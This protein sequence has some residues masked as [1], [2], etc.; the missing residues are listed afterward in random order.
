MRNKITHCGGDLAQHIYMISIR[1]IKNFTIINGFLLLMGYLQYY[2]LEYV[3]YFHSTFITFISLFLIFATRNKILIAAIEYVGRNKSYINS[4]SQ[5][6]VQYENEFDANL[7][8]AEFIDCFM[9]INVWQ[10]LISWKPFHIVDLIQFIPISFM[11][12]IIFDFFHYW[13]HRLCHENKYLYRMFHKKHHRFQHVTPVVTFYQHPFDLILSNHIPMIIALYMCPAISS[14]QFFLILTYK[15][16]VEIAGH[17]GKSNKSSS[18]PQFMWLPRWLG[19]EMYTTDHDN[20]HTLNNCNYA[21]R[22]TLW[23]RMFGTYKNTSY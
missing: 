6:L 14:F 5:T 19:I 13:M 8:M 18:F 4:E 2:L 11:F 10:N 16:F 21:K 15:T 17:S 1:S 23:D 9:F 12:E 3:M 20:H 22:F 7:V